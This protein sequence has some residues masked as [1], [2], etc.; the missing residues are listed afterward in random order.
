MHIHICPLPGDFLRIKRKVA[1]GGIV[2]S[3]RSSI[4][5]T[6]YLWE[7]IAGTPTGRGLMKQAFCVAFHQPRFDL[8]FC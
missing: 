7:L 5:L 8:F 3:R 2:E 1:A 6:W 4:F